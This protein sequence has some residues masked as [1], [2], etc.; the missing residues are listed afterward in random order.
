MQSKL[1]RALACALAVA[2]VLVAAGP[3]SAGSY[4]VYSCGGPAGGANNLFRGQADGGMAAYYA[5]CPANPYAASD[6]TISTYPWRSITDG[7][8]A[9][10]V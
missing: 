8:A 3:A 2:A 6:D 9:R 5:N 4:T 10:T 7:R 1:M